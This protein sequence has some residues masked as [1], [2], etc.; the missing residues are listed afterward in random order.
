MPWEHTVAYYPLTSSSTTNDMKTSWTKYNL[1]SLWNTITYGTYQ[2]VDC[3]DFSWGGKCLKADITAIQTLTLSWWFYITQ[4]GT[5]QGLM[6]AWGTAGSLFGSWYNKN[7]WLAITSWGNP[8][9]VGAKVATWWHHICITKKSWEGGK[10]YLDGS[11]NI[12][13]NNL[14]ITWNQL[15]IWWHPTNYNRQDSF[16]GGASEII[17]EDKERTAEEVLDYYDKTKANYGIS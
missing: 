8:E 13:Q 6:L 5:Y 4:D 15:V 2:G 9:T 14:T 16:Y 17:Y 1:T 12:S 11:Y 7:L 3:A 10:L